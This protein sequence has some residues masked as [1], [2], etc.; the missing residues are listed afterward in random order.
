M[1]EPTTPAL[2]YVGLAFTITDKTNARK[3][4]CVHCRSLIAPGHGR[5]YITVS[6]RL[7]GYLCGACQINTIAFDQMAPHMR[8]NID[9]MWKILQQDTIMGSIAKSRISDLCYKADLDGLKVSEW[10]L[11]ELEKLEVVNYDNVYN[12]I[13]LY[14]SNQQAPRFARLGNLFQKDPEP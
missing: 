6:V 13:R 4:R 8:A 14:K 2:P 5:E 3:C 10:F 11:A 12:V 1:N 9:K 7:F